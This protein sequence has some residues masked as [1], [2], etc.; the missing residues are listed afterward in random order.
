MLWVRQVRIPKPRLDHTV[1]A[2]SIKTFAIFAC[3]NSS[4]ILR[5]TL[6]VV[7]T[8]SAGHVPELGLITIGHENTF[9]AHS[10]KT[11]PVG[12]ERKVKNFVVVATL[13]INNYGR[14][15]ALLR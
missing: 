15:A 12:S 9:V 5:V 6:V 13:A 2:G 8:I 11:A 10:A 7:N 1:V 3:H 14:A 4:N